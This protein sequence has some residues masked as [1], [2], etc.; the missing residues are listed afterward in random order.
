M[1]H[2]Y[3][4]FVFLIL[5]SMLFSA[6]SKS[7]NEIN[8]GVKENQDSSKVY[9][10]ANFSYMDSLDTY[11]MGYNVARD[12]AYKAENIKELEK[13]S[14]LIKNNPETPG[15]YLDRGNHYQNIQ[16][17]KEAIDDYN[18]YIQKVPNNYSAYLNRGTAY[19]QLKQYELALTDYAKVLELKPDDTISNFNRGIV[20]DA[21]GKPDEAVKEYS[22]VIGKDSL[23]AKAYLNR[24][25]SQEKL[26][27]YEFAI[28]DLSK[29]LGLNPKYGEKLK[30]K[31]EY[32]NRKK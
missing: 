31:I 21:L 11:Q 25:L 14:L 22:K 13:Q 8:T 17:Y 4:L 19:E 26:K 2:Y 27:N 7:N 24:G 12:S 6:C 23:L 29:A 28:M 30:Q 9:G 16:M 5:S 10:S 15:P 3:R 18:L 20:F 32:L 1:K